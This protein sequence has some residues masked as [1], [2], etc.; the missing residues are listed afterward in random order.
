MSEGF[1]FA[2]HPRYDL[3][4]TKGSGCFQSP[5]ILLRLRYEDNPKLSKY[6]IH[7]DTQPLYHEISPSG[8]VF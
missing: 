4:P 1:R 8:T 5:W 7:Y 3:S 2:A 6:G